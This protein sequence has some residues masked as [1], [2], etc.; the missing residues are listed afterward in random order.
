L[1]REHGE[2]ASDESAELLHV[3]LRRHEQQRVD[4]GYRVLECPA[5]RRIVVIEIAVYNGRSRMEISW[6]ARLSGA[7]PISALASLR[8]IEST[9]RL[10]MRYPTV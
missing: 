1:R 8:L 10:P 4:R 5:R 3:V 9:D 2:N 6:N 7:K